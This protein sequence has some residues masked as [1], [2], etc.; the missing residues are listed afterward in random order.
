MKTEI[1]SLSTEGK[2]AVIFRAAELIDETRDDDVVSGLR[3]LFK[4]LV[5]DLLSPSHEH[6]H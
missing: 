1:N 2:I 4:A 6:K 5:S 3:S